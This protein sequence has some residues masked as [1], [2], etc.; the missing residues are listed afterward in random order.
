MQFGWPRE[1]LESFFSKRHLTWYQLGFGYS[2]PSPFPL[3]IIRKYDLHPKWVVIDVDP[4]FTRQPSEMADKVLASSKFDAF[5]FRLE[6]VCAFYSQRWIHTF[7]PAMNNQSPRGDEVYFRSIKDGNVLMAASANLH[8]LV[9]TQT[10]GEVNLVQKSRCRAGIQSRTGSPRC[11]H[12]LY[13]RS[14]AIPKK[15]TRLGPP[16]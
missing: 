15:C 14:I 1:A 6:T 3:A 13:R 7:V 12:G 4:F 16:A 9:P 11:P 2:E 5:K 8:T 10:W